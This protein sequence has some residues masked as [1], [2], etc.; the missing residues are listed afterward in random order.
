VAISVGISEGFCGGGADQEAEL[1]ESV[2]EFKNRILA[3]QARNEAGLK[4]VAGRSWNGRRLTLP[5][6]A[7][8]IERRTRPS[9]SSDQTAAYRDHGHASYE[10]VFSR[11]HKN[12]LP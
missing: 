8:P 3:D 10:S 5:S 12:S 7:S 2:G 1:Q 11:P 6:V 4:G 9:K